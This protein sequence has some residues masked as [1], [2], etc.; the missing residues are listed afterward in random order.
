MIRSK[1]LRRF[2]YMLLVFAMAATTAAASDSAIETRLDTFFRQHLSQIQAPGFSVVVVQG[3]KVLLS[4]G[5]G[6]EVV[7]K[8]IPFTE[9][10]IIA[11]G[12]LTKSITAMAVLQLE[13][14]GL[15]NVDDPVSKYLPWFRSA[16]KAMSDTITLRMCLN[17]TTGLRAQ[18][19]TLM[20]NLSTSVD[21]LEKGVR[22]ISAY[23]MTR[24]P[25]E[26]FEYL[27]EGWNILGLII[28]KLTGMPYEQ[29][30]ADNIFAPLEMSHSAAAR[31]V[32]ASWPPAT[33]HYAGVTPKP[34]A[35]IHIQGSLP[36]GSGTYMSAENLG[37]YI[38][39]LVNG[40]RY[41]DKRV[42]SEQNIQKMWTPTASLRVIPYELGGTGEPA[43]Y[44]MG[45]LIMDLDG[46]TY[47]G[48]GGEFRTMSNQTLLDPKNKLAVG[49]LY[50][51]GILDS[52]TNQSSYHACYNALR[53]VKGLPLSDFAIPREKDPTL[54]DYVP[55]ALDTMAHTGT[56]LSDSGKRMNIEAGG[57]EG[58][59]AFLIESIYPADFD[60][61][62]V[63][64][65]GFVMRNILGSTQGYFTRSEAGRVISL[66]FGGEVFRRKKETNPD[67][68]HRYP[69]D[70]GAYAFAL[71]KSW[72]VDWNGEH[73][74]GNMVG[75]ADYTFQGGPIADSYETWRAGLTSKTDDGDLAELNELRNGYFFRV[76]SYRAQQS[77]KEFQILSLYCKNRDMN[78]L[79][80]LTTP[81]GMLTQAVIGTLNPFLDS[82]YIR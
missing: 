58:L 41:H 16:N 70:S 15:L 1:L 10:T 79:F 54:N 66:A 73:F 34:A 52:Y 56:F 65:T 32:I 44:G 43:H 20:Q 47:V 22:A 62:F 82:L 61:D 33:G 5:Y 67:A 77:G 71:P 64:D 19:A 42:L 24:K 39:A 17:N 38:Q 53:I 74:T 40:G 78:Y 75:K 37:H 80:S 36:A 60:V 28:E 4:R 31:K 8:E 51:T 69:S 3:E 11:I 72:R 68:V 2:M 25:G 23:Q 21:A 50:N 6:V 55:E 12:S 7:G 48:H 27:N 29:Y 14:K 13:E 49:L 46:D 81:Q 59:R 26:S 63:N 45:W 30:I 35:F 76:V 9:N 18:Q 57:S